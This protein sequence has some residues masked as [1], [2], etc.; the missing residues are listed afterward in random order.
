MAKYNMQPNEV[1]LLKDDRV[2]V[3]GAFSAYTDALILTNLNLVL[4]KKGVLGNSKG[5][6]TYPVNQ[7]KVYNQEAQTRMGKS[8]NGTALLEV[9][10][11][12][13]EEQF[14]FQSGGKKKILDWAAKINEVVTGQAAPEVGGG[15]GLALPG[16]ERV[17]GMLKDTLDVFKSKRGSKS[18]A[19]PRV[20]AKCRACGA[21]VAGRQGQPITC[22]YCGTAQQM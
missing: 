22:E 9:Y 19:G 17:A 3:G 16:A 7:I 12:N 15:P 2:M 1:V 21:P 4:V 8:R 14:S 5:I 13:G 20:A 11:V 18:D 10:F 6:R